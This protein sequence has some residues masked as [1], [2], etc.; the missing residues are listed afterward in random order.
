MTTEEDFPQCERIQADLAAGA[1]DEL[2]FGR[3]EPALAHFHRSLS[4]MLSA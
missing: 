1:A 4:A 3:N 2:I